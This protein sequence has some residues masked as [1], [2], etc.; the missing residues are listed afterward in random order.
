M[1]RPAESVLKEMRNNTKFRN[2]KGELFVNS[3]TT[4]VTFHAL[5]STV[6]II[7]S[8]MRYTACPKR[9][10]IDFGNQTITRAMH[11]E[12]Q[13]HLKSSQRFRE[14]QIIVC[15]PAVTSYF[16]ALRPSFLVEYFEYQRLAGVKKISMGE[17]DKKIYSFGFDPVSQ[18]I[19]KHYK[20]IGFL[21]MHSV[22]VYSNNASNMHQIAENSK[23]IQNTYCYLKY[24]TISDYVIVQDLD[25]VVAF[26]SNLYRNLP[27]AFLAAKD[28]KHHYFSFRLY[29]QSIARKCNFTK[30]F[31][32]TTDFLISR[33][34]LYYRRNLNP[35]KTIHSSHV[36]QLPGS[37]SCLI[38]RKVPELFSD[39]IMRKEEFHKLVSWMNNKEGVSFLRSLHFRT[40]VANK[41]YNEKDEQVNKDM[42]SKNNTMEFDWLAKLT[43]KLVKNTMDT[44]KKIYARQQDD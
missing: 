26:N 40:S 32:N 42:C 37:Y 33:A 9:I 11:V 15:L 12:R 14:P 13:L 39:E 18:Q 17:L 20:D 44:L 36:C 21:E 38:Y 7:C 2:E 29:D 8:F 27:R 31:R 30:D 16:D 24:A 28:K 3:A 19:L 23:P 25:E 22:S 6:F 41:F 1:N 35:G 5:R 10:T 34:N 43:P 4:H